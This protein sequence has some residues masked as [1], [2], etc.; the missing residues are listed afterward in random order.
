MWVVFPDKDKQ[1]PSPTEHSLPVKSPPSTL[2]FTVTD[3]QDRVT[4]GCGGESV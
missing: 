1:A 2:H 3:T 4:F